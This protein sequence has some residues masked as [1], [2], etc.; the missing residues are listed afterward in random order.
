MQKRKL[1]RSW[2]QLGDENGRTSTR[3]GKD[4]VTSVSARANRKIRV[5]KQFS[6]SC[7]SS[8]KL[9][10]ALPLISP[11]NY[12]RLLFRRL[13]RSFAKARLIVVVSLWKKRREASS[14]HLMRKY[15]FENTQKSEGG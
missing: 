6:E 7:S 13:L 9:F 14:A 11:T 4:D 1:S 12:L 10:S 2:L 3:L 15:V 8:S 5:V